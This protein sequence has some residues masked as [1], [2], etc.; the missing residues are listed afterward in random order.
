MMRVSSGV[1]QPGRMVPTDCRSSAGM[2]LVELL[3]AVAVLAILA[4]AA[5]PVSGRIM[6]TTR[7]AAAK[8]EMAAIAE[9]L[10]AYAQDRA[11]S[12]DHMRWG[13]FPPEVSGT[14]AY[15]TILGRDLE[16]DLHRVGWDLRL[17]QGWNGPYIRSDAVTADAG[18][19]GSAQT[20]RGHQVDPWGRYYIYRNRHASG[21][22][23][24]SV[25]DE[26]VVTLLSGGPDR[27]PRTSSDNIETVVY[28]GKAY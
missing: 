18:G 3:V 26:R 12:P 2:T 1:V 28:R 8:R 23:V 11:F 21:G 9:A 13:R 22:F 19:D 7:E 5:V 16:E 17:M 10:R 6:R 15:E 27:D 14:G 25:S 24:S 20:V 4:G